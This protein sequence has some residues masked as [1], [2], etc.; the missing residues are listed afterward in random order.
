MY[1]IK[2]KDYRFLWE[3]LGHGLLTSTGAKWHSRRKMLTPAF[4][5]KILEDFSQVM[6]QQSAILCQQIEKKSGTNP[7]NIFPLITHCALDIICETA[8]GENL[9][10]Q[11]ESDTDYVRE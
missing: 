8:M 9:N 2:G 6:S 3:W 5:F 7:F 1:Y 11:E 10:S 4:H